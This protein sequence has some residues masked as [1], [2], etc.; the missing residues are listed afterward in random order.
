M[1]EFAGLQQQ[2]DEIADQIEQAVHRVLKSGWFILGQELEEFEQ[3]FSGYIG[4]K[5]GIG[6][7]SGSDALLLAVKALGIGDEDET[8]QS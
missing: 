4:T 6:V 2:Y 7:N 1:I 3:E 8:R 5:F